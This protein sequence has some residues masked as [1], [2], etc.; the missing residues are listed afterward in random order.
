[1][2]KVVTTTH[3]NSLLES[4]FKAPAVVHYVL[5][6]AGLLAQCGQLLCDARFLVIEATQHLRKR[7]THIAYLNPALKG[8]Q[9]ARGT[10][11]HLAVQKSPSEPNNNREFQIEDEKRRKSSLVS[12]GTPWLT[13]RRNVLLQPT[14]RACGGASPTSTAA[15][16]GS[17]DIETRQKTHLRQ[18]A[19]V[20][21]EEVRHSIVSSPI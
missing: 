20:N 2:Q 11:T 12:I 21:R 19:R 3:V 15:Y 13:E 7:V 1:M 6:A 9:A 5:Q 16:T 17:C 4:P 14:P 8:L 18:D 10:P